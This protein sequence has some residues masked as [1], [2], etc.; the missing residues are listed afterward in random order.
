MFTSSLLSISWV[1]VALPPLQA[2]SGWSSAVNRSTSWIR[3][4]RIG[5]TGSLSPLWKTIANRVR[6]SLTISSKT[7]SASLNPLCGRA[8]LA[9]STLTISAGR[10]A[11]AGS[12]FS[13]PV[14]GYTGLAG[15]V[16]VV[17]ASVVDVAAVEVVVASSVAAGASVVAGVDGA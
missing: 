8:P 4:E 9:L 2:N 5:P 13:I 1:T 3:P 16:V 10:A 17:A 14:S 6:L 12:G 7:T 11:I 15:T